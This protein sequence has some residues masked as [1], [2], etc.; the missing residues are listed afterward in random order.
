MRSYFFDK[1][2][3]SEYTWDTDKISIVDVEIM[4][5]NICI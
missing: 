1:K 3:N 5:V 2:Y 4:L